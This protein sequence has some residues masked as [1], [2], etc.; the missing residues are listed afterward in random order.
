MLKRHHL[1]LSGRY[2]INVARF[3]AGGDVSR[4]NTGN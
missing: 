4:L 2:T 3:V 1:A